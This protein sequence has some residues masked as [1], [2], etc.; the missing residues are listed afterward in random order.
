MFSPFL[1][2]EEMIAKKLMC[3]HQEVVQSGELTGDVSILR[4]TSHSCSYF[5]GGISL[6]NQ[7]FFFRF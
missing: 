5:H 4:D 1:Q 2:L 7:T 3:F 6:V